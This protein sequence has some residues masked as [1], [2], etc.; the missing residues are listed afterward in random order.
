MRRKIQNS[1]PESHK[2]LSKQSKGFTLVELTIALAIIG[3]LVGLAAPQFSH[4]RAQANDR[5]A[6]SDAA[7]SAK[8]LAMAI[9]N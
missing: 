3:L 5:L 4:Y 2:K 8:L 1:M 9:K 7:S 6:E